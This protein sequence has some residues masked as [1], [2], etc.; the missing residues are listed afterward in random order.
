MAD[1]I[2]SSQKRGDALMNKFKALVV[3]ANRQQCSNFLS[4]ATIT[5]GDEFQAIMQD[6]VAGLQTIIYLEEEIIRQQ[7]NFQLRYVLYY[8]SIDTEINPDIA[9]EM[10]G[11]GLTNARKAL[12][13]LKDESNRFSIQGIQDSLSV[14]LNEAFIVY[15]HLMNRW[16]PD[17][18][19]L[20]TAFW[21]HQDY[22][23]VAE[24]LNKDTS[25]MWRRERS[26][27]LREYKAIRS[28]I[29]YLGTQSN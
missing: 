20:V 26:L 7:A 11:E 8:G 22:K 2:G 15:D 17:D 16:K 27:N 6:L 1:V 25:L 24:V 3:S 21:K 4:P 9:Y 12:N 14:A 28:V 10:L 19:S 18:Y 29:N 23:K 13:S 5:L